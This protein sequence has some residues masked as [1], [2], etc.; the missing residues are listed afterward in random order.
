MVEDLNITMNVELRK[1][2]CDVEHVLILVNIETNAQEL[3]GNRS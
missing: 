1:Y 3:L 2:D